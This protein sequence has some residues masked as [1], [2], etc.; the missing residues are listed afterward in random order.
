MNRAV[1]SRQ[2]KKAGKAAK[3]AK[4]GPTANRS[5]GQRRLTIQQTLDLALGHHGAGRLPQAKKI[6]QQILQADP[7]HPV[8]LHLLGVVATQVGKNDIAV[9][10]ITQA[11]AIKPDYA[12]AH[13]N[14]GLA[15]RNL[16]Q[17]DEAA[18]SYRQ[19]LAIM[20]DYAKAHSNFG[21]VLLDLGRLDEAVA[22]HRKA[23]AIKPD[24]AEAHYNLGN[25]QIEM[26]DL[27][28]AVAC[29]QKA[30]SIQPD[31][32]LA[33]GNL[34]NALTEQGN[35]DEAV[36]CYQKALSIR[37]DFALAL[38]NLGNALIE[39]GNL[40][41]AIACCQKAVSIQPDSTEFNWNFEVAMVNKVK[42][43]ITNIGR[44]NE[45]GGWPKANR[46]ISPDVRNDRLKVNLVYGPFVDPITPPLGIASLKGYLEKNSNTQVRC[47]DLNLEWH[48]MMARGKQAGAEQ[49]RKG[50]KLSKNNDKFFDLDHY[51]SAS[52]DFADYLRRNHK[53]TQYSLC[54]D[55]P[56]QVN[57]VITYLKP[58]AL[59]G[60]PDVVG[61]SILFD[62]QLL[63]SVLLAKE[64]KQ[65]NPDTIVVFGGAGMLHSGEQ[66]I[67]NPYVDFV[68]FEAGEA[69]F[70]ELLNSIKAGKINEKIPG[71]AY[72]RAGKCI[73]NEAI[74]GNLN[75]DAYPDFSDY[76]LDR[77]FI[78]E[79]VIP[80][81][82]SKGCFWR[83]CS[84]CE[85]GSV[86]QYA[87]ASVNRVVDEIEHHSS[88]GIG[89][90]Q[91]VDEMISPK[92][93]K[94]ISH[95]IIRRK[96]KVFF[97]GT[98]R[99]SADFDQ[100]TLQ[101]MHI[102]GFRYV[103]WGVE[104]LNRRVLKLVN[105]GTSVKS[106]L[107]TLELSKG[108]GIRNHIFLIIGY[109]SEK[110]D[111]LFETMQTIYD[112]KE[113]IHQVQAGTYVLCKGT[114]IFL[115]PDKFDIEIEYTGFGHR[116]YTVK[117]KKGSTGKKATKYYHYYLDSFLGKVALAPA[118]GIFRDHALL[119]YANIP[120]EDHEKLRKKIPQPVAAPIP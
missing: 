31:Y 96:L 64:I 38:S 93:L 32:A 104:S 27:D 101:L 10:L 17:L 53:H 102:A 34:G 105:K 35:L 22:C 120:L 41:E 84:F 61:F 87:E 57:N 45:P 100:E 94:L 66:V 111:E 14:L 3:N 81:L 83:R 39:Q 113:N 43:F 56:P 98:L 59:A 13:N 117:Y 54:Q 110:P 5:S 24:L 52:I 90:F 95:E 103:I 112:N 37:P 20:P 11:L 21:L 91:F 42:D 50:E 33:L 89:Y 4:L 82:S 55:N 46:L 115:N 25:A 18:A 6:Y 77:Y 23:L 80:I 106:I 97:Y 36:A 65:E 63:S 72:K 69:S 48:T 8:A 51:I 49:L 76:H 85:E 7:N 119:H 114:E 9:D 26:G 28:E 86:N 78:T 99:P 30:L 118:F 29:Y 15:L 70:N 74:P 2:R 12:E 107:N 75:H 92:R 68:V 62:S 47:M 60:R 108:A 116:E 1:R 73:K 19:A 58:L 71:V 67:Q 88:N 44:G 40:D 16:G 109:P 79:V